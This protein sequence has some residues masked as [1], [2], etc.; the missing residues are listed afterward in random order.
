MKHELP[1]M[2][3]LLHYS[4]SLSPVDHLK[5]FT[6]MEL[7]PLL[8]TLPLR[9]LSK[10]RLNT[11]KIVCRVVQVYARAATRFEYIKTFL[12]TVLCSLVNKH[13]WKT[14]WTG[15]LEFDWEYIAFCIKHLFGL[16]R[17]VE[18]TPDHTWSENLLHNNLTWQLPQRLLYP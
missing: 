16:L 13:C 5:L 12:E 3:F 18:R 2:N 10:N 15:K 6:I 9:Y 8:Q 14:T 1:K 7:T 4:S 11:I 17:N